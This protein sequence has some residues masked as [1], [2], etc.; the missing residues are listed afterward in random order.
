MPSGSGGSLSHENSVTQNR[1]GRF[2]AAWPAATPASSTAFI[3]GRSP[4]ETSLGRTAW[5]VGPPAVY[6]WV[7][8][9]SNRVR[10]PQVGARDPP[11]GTQRSSRMNVSGA[12]TVE[13]PNG[14]RPPATTRL[15]GS[16]CTAPANAFT[17]DRYHD[18][19][20]SL[21]RRAGTLLGSFHACHRRTRGTSGVSP[22]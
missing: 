4:R 21:N 9:M 3:S 5:C 7:D 18:A 12:T 16:V 14:A 13:C 22:E 1:G 17:I 11:D 8:Q 10:W 19:E 20:L 15:P 6:G 2:E